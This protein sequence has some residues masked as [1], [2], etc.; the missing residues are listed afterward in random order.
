MEYTE[1]NKRAWE[2]AFDNRKENFGDENHI[3]LKNEKLPF[4]TDDMKAELEKINFTGKSVAHFCCNNGRELLSLTGL[5][6]ERAVGFDIA[7]NIIEQARETTEKAG[8]KGCEFVACNILDI[9]DKYHNQFD[10]VLLTIGA[11]CWFEDLTLFYEKASKCLKGGG[12]VIMYEI[13]PFEFMLP[14]PDEE[15]FDGENPNKFTYSYFRSD[16][17]ITSSMAYISGQQQSSTFTSFSHTMGSI[18][19]AMAANGLK[20]VRLCEYDYSVSGNTDV[21]DGKGMPL[22][23]FLISEKI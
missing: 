19:N 16:P 1:A 17:W 15:G 6:V 2:Q 18:I 21:Y 14:Y 7:E 4:F 5:G 23:Y 20:T 22:S 3:K 10:V 11:I 12:V 9:P 8:I 13:H